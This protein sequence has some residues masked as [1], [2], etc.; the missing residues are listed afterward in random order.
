[1]KCKICSAGSNLAFSHKVLSRYDVKYY[2]CPECE[3]LFTETP[4]W[5]EEAYKSPINLSD[6]GILERNIY[7]SRAVSI[8]ILFYFDSTKK[9]LDYAGGYG[10]FT[11]LMR[12]IG[13]DFY[14]HDD[15]TQNLLARGFEMK[16]ENYELLTAFEVFEH[17]ENPIEEIRKMLEK[18][19]DILFSTLILPQDIPALDWWYYGFEHGQHISFYSKKTF[20]TIAKTLKLKYT[21]LDKL[22]LLSKN[23]KIKISP[24]LLKLLAKSGFHL[25]TKLKLKS[26]TFSDHLY[27]KNNS[28]V[29]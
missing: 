29:D 12:D 27:F 5:L 19:D 24:F 28:P 13:F 21:Y 11:R 23:K 15:Y 17:F 14:W 18:S 22:H 26:K 9:F 10:I 3:Y 16:D 6:T 2:K 4:Y 20:E 1:M 25:I 8:L 7:F